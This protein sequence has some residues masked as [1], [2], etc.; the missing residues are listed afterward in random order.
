VVVLVGDT[1]CEPL[2]A[3]G[4]LQPSLAVQLVALVLDHVR[5]VG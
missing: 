5:V 2:V 1:L 4:P 3:C